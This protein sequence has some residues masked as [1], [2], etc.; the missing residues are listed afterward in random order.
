MASVYLHDG[1]PNSIFLSFM[2]MLTFGLLRLLPIY[3]Y[4]DV[5]QQNVLPSV[6]LLKAGGDSGLATDHYTVGQECPADCPF[7]RQQQA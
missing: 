4:S 1:L 5:K 3:L 7:N 6:N 2:S